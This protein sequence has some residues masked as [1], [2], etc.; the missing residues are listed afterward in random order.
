MYVYIYIYTYT[1]TT[2]HS[3]LH[4]K[5]LS[6]QRSWRSC[7]FLLR[8]LTHVSKRGMYGTT[9]L[10]QFRHILHPKLQTLNRKP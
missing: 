2:K 3:D 4:I 7:R 1:C 8:N 5:A 9:M 10:H 6:S